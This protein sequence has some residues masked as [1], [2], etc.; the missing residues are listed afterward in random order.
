MKSYS[1]IIGEN[2]KMYRKAKGLTQPKLGEL[3]G[4]SEST[5][6]KYEAGAVEPSFNILSVISEA[7]GVEIEDLATRTYSSEE[8]AENAAC[9]NFLYAKVQE[10]DDNF[11]SIQELMEYLIS[12]SLFKNQFKIDLTKYSKEKQNEI[13]EDI[14]KY[15]EWICHREK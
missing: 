10:L 2:I 1:Q 11:S 8:E 13:I 14:C 3:I 9:E 4:K 6:R 5:I 7:L 15:I 12:S